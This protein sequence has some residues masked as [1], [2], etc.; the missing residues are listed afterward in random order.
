MPEEMLWK[1]RRQV[2]K[3]EEM[4]V[5]PQ[6]KKKRERETWENSRQTKKQKQRVGNVTYHK[7]RGCHRVFKF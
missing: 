7:G 2:E 3:S 5:R 1:K 4:F 6:G